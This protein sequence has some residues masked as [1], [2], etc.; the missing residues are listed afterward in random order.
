M[1]QQ[2]NI[3]RWEQYKALL[4]EQKQV[5]QSLKEIKKHIEDIKTTIDVLLNFKSDENKIGQ[6]NI[7]SPCW[8]FDT[9]SVV[10]SQVDMILDTTQ[11]S[12]NEALQSQNRYE[13]ILDQL[14]CDIKNMECQQAIEGWSHVIYKYLKKYISQVNTEPGAIH[15]S[16]ALLEPQKEKNI[17]QDIQ[18]DRLLQ[19]I[20]RE[21]NVYISKTDTISASYWMHE[22]ILVYSTLG[23]KEFT[24]F[25]IDIHSMKQISSFDG[26]ILQISDMDKADLNQ[27]RL[28]IEPAIGTLD[29]IDGKKSEF[30]RFFVDQAQWIMEDN[31][32]NWADFTEVYKKDIINE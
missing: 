22:K 14:S 11:T 15:M 2:Q 23:T 21:R 17:H 1:S 32:S 9:V 28:W 13:K 20:K 7:E 24:Q 5:S 30:V 3:S 6:C 26:G 29:D 10:L 12:L 8:F 19:A 25:L 27:I 18:L 4:K 31:K 16:L